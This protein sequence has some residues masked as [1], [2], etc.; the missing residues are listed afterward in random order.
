MRPALDRRIDEALIGDLASSG[1]RFSEAM[2]ISTSALDP[3]FGAD[4]AKV[5]FDLP[6]GEFLS[7]RQDRSP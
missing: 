1:Q 2:E 4:D 5:G 7:G 3:H 6:L